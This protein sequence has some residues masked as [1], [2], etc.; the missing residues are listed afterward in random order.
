MKVYFVLPDKNTSWERSGC[1]IIRHEGKDAEVWGIKTSL[2]YTLKESWWRMLYD[3]KC[4]PIFDLYFPRSPE[5]C[6]SLVVSLRST[7]GN[8]ILLTKGSLK[9]PVW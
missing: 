9:G 4:F 2:T 5:K 6:V 1:F 3:D 7:S 8:P